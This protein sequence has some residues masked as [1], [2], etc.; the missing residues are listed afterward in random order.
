MPLHLLSTFPLPRRVG[1]MLP[2]FHPL[3]LPHLQ[4]LPSPSHLLLHLPLPLLTR[5][6]SQSHPLL[7]LV[8]F[9]LEIISQRP[10]LHP[11]CKRAGKPSLSGISVWNTKGLKLA[12][13]HSN[14]HTTLTPKHTCT[15][16]QIRTTHRVFG[17]LAH[18]ERINLRGERR[19]KCVNKG[20]ERCIG[21][22]TLLLSQ[23]YTRTA[24]ALIKDEAQFN[25]TMHKAKIFLVKFLRGKLSSVTNPEALKAC[26]LHFALT[27]CSVY[28]CISSPS[29]L[30]YLCLFSSSS[31]LT[32][33]PLLSPPVSLP[34]PP[35]LPN[36]FLPPL[37]T[38][39]QHC[40]NYLS[41]WAMRSWKRP[42]HLHLHLQILSTSRPYNLQNN[43]YRH[44]PPPPQLLT[45]LLHPHITPHP[46]WKLSSSPRSSN[47]L[48]C[49]IWMN[50]NL[51]SCHMHSTCAVGYCTKTRNNSTRL[52][53]SGQ[54]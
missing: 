42:Q 52:S 12:Q 25:D 15:Q 14:P 7:P 49:T 19:E 45:Y 17:E 16:T 39:T 24:S 10:H 6:H 20:W 44:Q 38:S 26:Y 21:V 32:L 54:N 3:L 50:W 35:L 36:P 9:S 2:C 34:F 28:S 1:S 11:S 27:L 13:M 18:K 46:H 43:K 37:R 51:Y 8:H 47:P 40:W 41:T 53:M 33:F 22:F 31:L 5:P 29:P 23:H 4:L 48:H 30:P